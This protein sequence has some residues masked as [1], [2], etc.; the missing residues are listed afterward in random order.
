[1]TEPAVALTDYA[2]A[3]ETAALAMLLQR[4]RRNKMQFWLTVYFASLSVASLCGGTVHGFFLDRRSLA[5]P[6]LWSTTLLAIGVTALATWFM[7]AELLSSRRLARV[8]RIAAAVQLGA[9]AVVVLFI[10]NA[11]WTAIAI[12]LPAVMFLL[13]TILIKW[14]HKRRRPLLL[15]A[16]A[17]ALSLAAAVLQQTGVGIHHHFDHNALYHVIQAIAVYLLYRGG[18]GLIE[19]GEI[20]PA[21]GIG[22]VIS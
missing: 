7:G 19:R 3:V 16:S 21:A 2:L 5:R 10:T 8:V 11:F 6:I 1:M 18:K 17:L 15:A 20:E 13:A 22:Q 14:A 9:Y 12:N 4:S